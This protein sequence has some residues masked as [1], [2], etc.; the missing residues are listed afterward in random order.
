M[1]QHPERPKNPP[2]STRSWV[3]TYFWLVRHVD[4]QTLNDNTELHSEI[5]NYDFGMPMTFTELPDGTTFRDIKAWAFEEII[6]RLPEIRRGELLD[7]LEQFRPHNVGD[8]FSTIASEAIS[9]LSSL[10]RL[11]DES[12]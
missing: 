8:E 1:S 6:D 11:R 5:S 10:I 2:I 12:Y 3:R 4:P 9:W 7:M